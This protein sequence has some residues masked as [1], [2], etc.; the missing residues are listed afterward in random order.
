MELIL[1]TSPDPGRAAMAAAL[2]NAN[3]TPSV[4]CAIATVL[5]PGHRFDPAVVEAFEELDTG[6]LLLPPTRLTAELAVRAAEII[7]MG[8]GTTAIPSGG[9]PVTEWDIPD[10]TD[11]PLEEVR[12]VCDA[13]QRSVESF[14]RDRHWTGH[15]SNSHH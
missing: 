7:S 11:Q 1:V 13:I 12:G 15:L 3:V 9:V 5:E 8:W 14:L 2:F 6:R 10:P 4:A